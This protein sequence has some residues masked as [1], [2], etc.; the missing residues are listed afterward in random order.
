MHRQD[1]ATSPAGLDLHPLVG[2]QLQSDRVLFERAL[3]DLV[4]LEIQFAGRADRAEALP[5][6][7]PSASTWWCAPSGTAQTKATP[8]RT[9]RTPEGGTWNRTGLI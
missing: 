4:P 5:D 7:W 9:D 8:T 3:G 1:S 2:G 6:S